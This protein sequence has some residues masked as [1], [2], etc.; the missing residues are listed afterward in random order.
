MHVFTHYFRGKTVKLKQKATIF[1][2]IL[3]FFNVFFFNFPDL[4]KSFTPKIV[5]VK[6]KKAIKIQ[7]IMYRLL[8]I[9]NHF[10]I[11]VEKEKHIEEA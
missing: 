3:V 1:F 8:I 9:F 10:A 5:L 11:F 7:I 4:E 6:E 2:E